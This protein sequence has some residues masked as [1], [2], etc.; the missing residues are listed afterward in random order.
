VIGVRFAE[1]AA[2]PFGER[3]RAR[4]TERMQLLGTRFTFETNSAQLLRLVRHAYAALPPHRLPGRGPRAR[5]QLTLTAARGARGTPAPVQ[6][7]AAPGLACGVSMGSSL[8]AIAPSERSALIVVPHELLRFPYN[9]RYELLE[10][11][12]YTLAARIQGLV[13]LH[14]ACVGR[15]GRGVLLVGPSGSGKSTLTLHCLLHGLDF[16][17]EDSV[18]VE[19]RTLRASGVASFLHLRPDS[20]RFLD[21]RTARAVRAAPVIRRRSGIAKFEL[22]LRRLRCHLAPAP[23]RIVATVFLSPAPPGKRCRISP[24][25]PARLAA[26]LAAEQRYAAGQPGWRL[27][28]QRV[29]RLPAFRLRRGP[30]PLEAV[31]VLEE[32]LR[33][34]GG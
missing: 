14:A 32:L 22:D 3:R 21:A 2:D 11:A 18:L 17:A 31:E 9:V 23:L 13:P 4:F 10:F 8:A 34:T 30:H 20:L 1:P 26:R 6:P 28:G 16:L 29:A 12:V 27:F 19:P 5:V 33:R 7:L 25:S 24:L 15:D